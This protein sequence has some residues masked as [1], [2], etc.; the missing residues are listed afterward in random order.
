MTYK[1]FSINII[2]KTLNNCFDN[3]IKMVEYLYDKKNKKSDKK[4]DC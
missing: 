1:L 3:C 2:S 4:R